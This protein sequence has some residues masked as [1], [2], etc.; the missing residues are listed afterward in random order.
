M[1]ALRSLDGW[2]TSMRRDSAW[3][4]AD[5]PVVDRYE[6]EPGRHVKVNPIANWTRR[7]AWAYLKEYDLP[8]N[9][10]YDLGYASI[11]CAPCTRMRFPEEASGRAGGPAA[12]ERVRDPRGRARPPFSASTRSYATTQSASRASSTSRCVRS[13][14]HVAVDLDREGLLRPHLHPRGVV[15]VVDVP[16]L[17]V[18]RRA[19]H[20]AARSAP[21]AAS[22][23]GAPRARRAPCPARP[24]ASRGYLAPCSTCTDRCVRPSPRATRPRVVVVDAHGEIPPAPGRRSR[25][26]SAHTTEAE[27]GALEVRLALREP[28]VQALHGG[29]VHT[30]PAVDREIPTVRPAE[31]E[32]ARARPS[33]APR[34]IS[35]PVASTGSR[36][37][38]SA[39]A[40][41]FVAPPGKHAERHVGPGQTVQRFVDGA[42]AGE[43]DDEV[44]PVVPRPGRRARSA[45]P[46]SFVSETSRRKSAERAFSMTASVGL[47]TVRATGFTMRR[48]RWKRMEAWAEYGRGRPDALS[49]AT[50]SVRCGCQPV[51]ADRASPRR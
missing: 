46:R 36:G 45:W 43:H 4:R 3:T 26:T 37:I 51:H 13:S 39:R 47:D 28:R 23:G 38:P 27:R 22:A 25:P 40:R 35:T 44:D 49:G 7:D 1:Q 42:V 12:E 15:P 10:L 29:R 18:P 30:G 8:H 21:R 41:M 6:L 17:H 34:A 20:L 24:R 9:P 31:V 19:E 33:S 14:Q 48:R 11:G 50:G 2:V 32:L 16:A 5:P